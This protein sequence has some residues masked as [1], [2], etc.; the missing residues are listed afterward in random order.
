MNSGVEIRVLKNLQTHL[1]RRSDFAGNLGSI[2]SAS[3]SLGSVTAAMNV[4]Y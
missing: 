3:I 4:D 2:S 1:N